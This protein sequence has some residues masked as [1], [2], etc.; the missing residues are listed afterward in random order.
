MQKKEIIWREILVQARTN[1]QTVFTQKDLALRLKVSLSTV[2]N[3][4]KPLRETHAV[5][6]SA[7]NFR[8]FNYQKLLYIWANGRRLDKDIFYRAAISAEPKELE[9]L[10]PPQATFALYSAYT[11]K[12]NNAPVDYDHI[13]IYSDRKNIAEIEQRLFEH[14]KIKASHNFFVIAKDPFLDIYGEM[15][16]EQIYVD[17]WNAPEWYAK[18]F[19]KALE[20]KLP[21]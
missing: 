4:L 12:F 1:K 7:R 11:Q 13:Y 18:D 9:G 16:P 21:L 6:A 20:D 2:F 8:L 10:M 3:A 5:E 17:I 19:L 14:K 15:P